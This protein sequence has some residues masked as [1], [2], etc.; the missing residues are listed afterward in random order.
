MCFTRLFR[1]LY[2]IAVSTSPVRAIYSIQNL[3]YYF[4]VLE[5]SHP[6]LALSG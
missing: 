1:C 5:L 2:R 3:S 6:V 4:N